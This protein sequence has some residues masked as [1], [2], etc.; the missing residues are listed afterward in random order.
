VSHV[1]YFG[2]FNFLARNHSENLKKKRPNFGAGHIFLNVRYFQ[3]PQL[4][5]YSPKERKG[6]G[7]SESAETVA[8]GSNLPKYL[9]STQLASSNNQDPENNENP[10]NSVQKRS[11]VQTAVFSQD[12]DFH[13]N[14]AY[15]SKNKNNLNPQSSNSKS[16]SNSMN[17]D[18]NYKTTNYQGEDPLDDL[19]LARQRTRTWIG[20]MSNLSPAALSRLKRELEAKVHIAIRKLTEST[21]VPE[22]AKNFRQSLLDMFLEELMESERDMRNAIDGL[23]DG[24]SLN[25]EFR[26]KIFVYVGENM[27][28]GS[29]KVFLSHNAVKKSH[30]NSLL[31]QKKSF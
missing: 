8:A 5:G 7:D 11:V 22:E 26:G 19:N 31:S 14:S 10:A 25:V 30:F 23:Q 13:D 6:Y 17:S 20:A 3:K 1:P 24:F 12:T 15:R 4:D 29:K 21:G 9:R 18:P 28:F 16:S 27:G 2:N